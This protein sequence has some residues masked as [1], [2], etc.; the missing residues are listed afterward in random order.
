[1]TTASELL[2]LLAETAEKHRLENG[3]PG[4]ALGVAADGEVASTGL[5]V[6]SVAD[7][8]PVTT[9]TLFRLCS[10]TKIFAATLAMTL[11]EEGVLDLDV[12]VLAYYPELTLADA[13]ARASLTMRHLL[14]HASGL[15]SELRGDLESFGR[16]DDAL[17]RVASAYGSL[18]QFAPVGELWGYCNTG[19]WLAGAVL[20]RLAGPSFEQAVRR[21]VLEPL[22]MAGSCFFAEEAVLGRVALPHRRGAAGSPEHV[23]IPSFAFPRARVPSGGVIAGVDDLLRF[24]G[25]HLGHGSAVLSRAGLAAMREPQIPG[26]F[27]GDQ[28]GLGWMTS[29]PGGTPVA[30]HS[31]SYKGYCTRLTLLPELGVAVAVL[32]NSDDGGRLCRTVKEAALDHLTGWR[33]A[34]VAY[35]GL[36]PARLAA[37]AG[38]YAIPGVDLVR[39]APHEDGLRLALLNGTAQVGESLCRATSETEFEIVQGQSFGSRVVF[40]PGSP[41]IRIGLRLGARLS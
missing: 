14:T 40:F 36:A 2:A 26:D 18:R 33:P 22:G 28:Q 25:L 15:E 12:P 4:V 30:E 19:Y 27:P 17:D 6:T 1:M 37:Y 23:P 9:G 11:V 39:I 38:D 29:A 35:T 13:G 16:N 3:V 31:G 34:E 8:R 21:R 41:A 5:G 24:A 10:I 7:P 20:A 32:T